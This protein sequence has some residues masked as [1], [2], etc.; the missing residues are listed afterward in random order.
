MKIE[1]KTAKIHELKDMDDKVVQISFDDPQVA[2]TTYDM[3]SNYKAVSINGRWYI[4]CSPE[5]T[6]RRKKEWESGEAIPIG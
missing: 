4:R 2:V 1:T 5:E 3:G 6:L